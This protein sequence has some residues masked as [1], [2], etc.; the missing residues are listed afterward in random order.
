FSVDGQPISDQ[1]SRIFSN[2]ISVN[3]IQEMRTIQGA[4]PAE[5]GDKTSLIVET[6]TRSGL[7]SGKPNGSLSLAYASFDTPTAS[8]TLSSGTGTLGHFL[9]ADGI[10]RHR[11]LHTPE[12]QPL[13][14]DGNAENLF[15]RM[16]WKPSDTTSVH[17]NLSV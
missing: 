16:D 15:D 9:A 5:Y 14:S 6:T 2:Q 12:F 17:L 3:T 11:F 7:S 4:P 8:V 1:Q 10:N 13:H